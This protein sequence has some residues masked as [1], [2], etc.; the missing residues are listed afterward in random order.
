MFSRFKKPDAAAPAAPAA[1]PAA[2]V[3]AEASRPV[4]ARRT[5][6]AAANPAQVVA[7]DKEKKRKERMGEI[8]VELHKRNI[9]AL[10]REISGL[11]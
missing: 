1:K 3:L 10:R 9:E 6:A 4:V 8:K 11:R 7:A 2:P 5:G